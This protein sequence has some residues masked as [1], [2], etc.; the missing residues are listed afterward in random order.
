MIKSPRFLEQMRKTK[1]NSICLWKNHCNR[2]TQKP[3]RKEN[4]GRM[5]QGTTGERKAVNQHNPGR[6]DFQERSI[7][8]MHRYK[9][10]Y[11]NWLSS[12]M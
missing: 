1:S 11:F 12:E 5:Y 2:S 8:D 9:E 3:E 6:G 4:E 7:E 10:G